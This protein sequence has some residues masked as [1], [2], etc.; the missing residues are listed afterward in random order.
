MAAGDY[1]DI[2]GVKRGASEAEIKRAYREKAKLY[3]PDHNP[4]DKKAE[5]RF[6]EVQEAYE[7]LR[8]PQ[9]REMYDQYGRSDFGADTHAGEWRSAPG[10]QRVYTWSGREGTGVGFENINEFLRNFGMGG[11]GAGGFEEVFGR[12]SGR[13]SA[14]EPPPDLDLRTEVMITFEQALAGCELDIQLSVAGS[15]RQTIAVK[16]PAGIAD[17]Q[18]VRVRGK[19]NRSADGRQGDVLITIRVAP[20]RHFRREGDDIHLEVPISVI[21]ATL[22]ARINVPTIHGHST[23]TIPPGSASGSRLRLKEQGIKTAEGH[24]G[25][26]YLILKIVPPHQLSAEQKQ[27]FNQLAERLTDDPRAELGW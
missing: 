11:G 22:G 26:Q 24:L 16:V 8:D 27:L 19:G 6:K 18:V 7:V 4:G 14:A 12:S 13:R 3:H 17:G 25:H 15:G 10:G 21:E 9:K 2:L 23:V 20:H 5:A 1:Y